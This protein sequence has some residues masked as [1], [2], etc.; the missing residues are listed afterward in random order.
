M[1][2][3]QCIMTIKSDVHVKKYKKAKIN[4]H[5]LS[6]NFTNLNE[7]FSNMNEEVE[8]FNG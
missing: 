5:D 8:Q 1:K 6:F 7:I 4:K 3:C 2:L